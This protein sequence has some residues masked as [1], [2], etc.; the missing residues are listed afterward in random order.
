M[1]V[2]L[3]GMV[4]AML[5]QSKNRNTVTN[6]ENLS[7]E[8]RNSFP[9]ASCICRTIHQ[10]VDTELLPFLYFRRIFRR[11]H[12]RQC[13]KSKNSETNLELLMRIVPPKW[14]LS[15]TVNL[16]FSLKLWASNTA[17]SISPLIFGTSRIVDSS[18]SPAFQAILHTTERHLG[19]GSM[20][21][22]AHDI[23]ALE[24]LLRELFQSHCA[25]VFDES[26]GG[27][28]LLYVNMY[29]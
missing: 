17:W 22:A 29:P 3:D 20:H 18:E 25:S 5:K 28:T 23:R 7:T 21:S 4:T 2:M 1:A 14:L 11:N 19:W 13:P 8:A 9:N 6:Q 24:M 12:Y 27:N 26:K 16:G 10:T 15:H